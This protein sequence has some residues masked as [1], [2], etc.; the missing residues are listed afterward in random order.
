M[1]CYDLPKPC[2]LIMVG[3]LVAHSAQRYKASALSAVS[4]RSSL[5]PC[6]ARPPARE[7]RRAGG[8]SRFRHQE[9]NRIQT[10]GNVKQKKVASIEQVPSQEATSCATVDHMQE[11]NIGE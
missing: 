3:S 11:V 10:R 4:R 9:M 8:R 7:G 1:R 2:L 5:R 6:T